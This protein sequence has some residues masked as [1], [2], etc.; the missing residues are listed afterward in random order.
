MRTMIHVCCANCLIYPLKV[1]REEGVEVMGF[2]YNPNIHPYQEY[3]RRLDTVREYTKKVGLKMIYRDEYDLEGFLR[4]VVFREGERCRFCYH[5][6]LE[7]TAQ[8]A[9]R[10]KFDTFTSTLLY[11]K[12]QNHQLIQEIGKTLAKRYGVEF[13]YRD[14]RDG[15]REGIEVSKALG[16]YR[17]QY[18]GCIYSEK[19]RYLGK[20]R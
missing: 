15:W 10:G 8:V 14:F 3:R 2:F 5:L 7:A 18:C 9:A 1:L 12:H 19:E 11:S 17:Q 20:R 4:G 16:L 6:R 13:L